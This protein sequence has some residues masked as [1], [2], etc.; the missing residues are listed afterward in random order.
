MPCCT[1]DIVSSRTVLKQKPRCITT[2]LYGRHVYLF[3]F[4]FNI[5]CKFQIT[6]PHLSQPRNTITT[7]IVEIHLNFLQ[8]IDILL[9][10]SYAILYSNTTLFS[11]FTVNNVLYYQDTS[12]YLNFQLPGH[13]YLSRRKHS[14]LREAVPPIQRAL[15]L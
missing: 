13:G 5:I 9:H 15:I 4:I 6:W 3:F 2:V 10:I 12:T 7:I 11:R 14:I 1:V 8:S